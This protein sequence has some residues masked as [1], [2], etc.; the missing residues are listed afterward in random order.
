MKVRQRWSNAHE[1][2]CCGGGGSPLFDFKINKM[3][4]LVK[5]EA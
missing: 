5:K 1:V 4:N 2:A 3:Y